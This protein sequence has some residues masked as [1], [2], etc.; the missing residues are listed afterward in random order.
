MPRFR[1][2]AAWVGLA[3][4][5]VALL[6]VVWSGSA[7]KTRAETE[8]ETEQQFREEIQQRTLP[9]LVQAIEGLT[10]EHEQEKREREIRA[11]EKKKAREELRRLCRA[12]KL[13][14]ADLCGEVG[15]SD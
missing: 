12:G 11:E 15:G 7:W 3:A 14:D 8:H 1:V 2:I 4:G 9:E 6:L 10:E 13:T 5:A